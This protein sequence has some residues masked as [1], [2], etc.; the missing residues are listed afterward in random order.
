MINFFGKYKIIFYI[1]NFILILLYLF[2][3]SLIGC[4]LYDD[5]KLQ[6]QIT[7]DFIIS[8]NHLYAFAFLSLIA[9]LTFKKT[10]KITF[11]ILYLITISVVLELFHHFIPDRSFEYSDLFGNLIGVIIIIIFFNLLKKYENS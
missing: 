2:P 4:F 8:T 1:I 11:I 5:C 10:D 9:F 3:G 6:P 7:P